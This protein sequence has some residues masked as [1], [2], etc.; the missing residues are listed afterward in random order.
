MLGARGPQHVTRPST[1][2]NERER[3]MLANERKNARVGSEVDR[4]SEAKRQANDEVGSD[5]SEREKERI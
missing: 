1:C 4:T 5:G 3:R 2:S